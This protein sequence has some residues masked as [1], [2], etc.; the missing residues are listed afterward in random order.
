MTLP[1]QHFVYL[2]HLWTIPLE[3]RG[4]LLVF[5]LLHGPGQAKLPVRLP[6]L[7]DFGYYCSY[8][9]KWD[10]FIFVSGI[11]LAELSFIRHDCS[12]AS[13]SFSDC[14]IHQLPP[15]INVALQTNLSPYCHPPL[16]FVQ[17]TP[18]PAWR[19][20]LIALTQSPH[21]PHIYY[22]THPLL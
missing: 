21:N 1:V 19:T 15:N 12:S 5:N 3:Y 7:F 17:A 6:L 20:T 10:L 4:S 9:T 18:S 16:T 2:P 11:V 8:Y 22:Y 13:S 14:L